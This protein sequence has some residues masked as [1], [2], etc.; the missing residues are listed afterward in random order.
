MALS[1][2]LLPELEKEAAGTRE[3]LARIPGD[4]LDWTPHQKSMTFRGLATHLANVPGW[5]VLTINGDHFD[6]GGE[7]PRRDPVSMVDEALE[8]FDRNVADAKAALAA[9][10]DETLLGPWSLL[11]G[12]KTVFTLPRIAVVRG[13]VLN[14]MIHHRAQLG[15][16]LRLNDVSVPSLYGPTAD[17]AG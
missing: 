9:A 8:L 15:V 2:G 14:H 5:T 16:Y 1:D 12:D 13:M 17:E 4:K 11:A 7:P 10:G 3:S 6:V